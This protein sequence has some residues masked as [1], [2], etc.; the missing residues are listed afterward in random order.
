[1]RFLVIILIIWLLFFFS[2]E[3]LVGAINISRVAYPFA[4]LMAILTILI[5]QLRRAPLWILLVVP[6]PVFLVLKAWA[7]YEL[8][9]AAFPLTV[10]EV[11]TIA[12]TTILAH[13]VG[14]GLSEFESAVAHITIGQAA[15]LPESFSTDQAEMYREV[16]RARHHQRPLSLMAIGI[17]E[18][19]IQVALERMVQEAQQAMMRRYVLS[20]VARA[21]CGELE[22][23]NI[24][25]QGEGHFLVL[26]PEA[27]PQNVNEL[28]TKLCTVVSEQVGVSLRIGTASFPSDAVTFESLVEKASSEMQQKLRPEHS[29]RSRNLAVKH[30]TT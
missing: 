25:A 27:S 29:P 26:L 16:K 8:W 17:E 5:P 14:N 30:Q 12:V 4:P 6:I 20:D 2:I 24:V 23:Y 1:M 22:D 19:S 15:T 11:C 21:L 10:T 7:G 3:R 28:V 9:A 18:A 13:W